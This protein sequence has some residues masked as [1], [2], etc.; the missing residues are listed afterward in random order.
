M[1]VLA[2]HDLDARRRAQRLR[3]GSGEADS[4]GGHAIQVRRLVRGTA[5]A[6]EPLDPNVIGHD[7]QDV[8]F[9]VVRAS[10]ACGK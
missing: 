3:V 8:G 1:V 7:Q 5:V 4:L 10:A 2:R 6:T 9:R